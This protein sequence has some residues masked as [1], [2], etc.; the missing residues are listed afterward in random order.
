MHLDLADDARLLL[1]ELDRD[2]PGAATTTAE[3][4]P[5]LDVFETTDAV[6]VVID[7]PGVPPDHLRVAVRRTTLIIVGAKVT[8]AGESDMRYHLA[9]RSYGR[10]ARAVRLAVAVDATRAHARA[11][12]GELRVSLPRI[13]ERRGVV[14]RVPVER[15]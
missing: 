3:C 11:S 7:V 8:P 15:A 4:R 5:P 10:F 12:A 1:I 6:E 14:F 2:V 9:E 13:G